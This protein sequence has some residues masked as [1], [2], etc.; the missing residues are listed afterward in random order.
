MALVR[1]Y[2]LVLSPL[3]GSNCR[4]LPT[5]SAYTAEAISRH[6]LWAG[7]WMGIAR[8]QRCGPLGASGF[9]PVPDRLPAAAAWYAPG[10]YGRWTGAHID[11]NTRLDA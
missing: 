5:C 7:T 10:R 6:G 9:D 11:P 4:Y 2:Q 3:L 1:A 8:L